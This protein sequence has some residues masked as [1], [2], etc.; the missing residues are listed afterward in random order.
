M[1]YF[2]SLL[3]LDSSTFTSNGS[4]R[5]SLNLDLGHNVKYFTDL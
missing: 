5:E 4:F 2:S 1:P 3:V